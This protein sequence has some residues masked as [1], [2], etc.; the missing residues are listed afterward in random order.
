[1][2]R[3]FVLL[4]MAP[5][6]A[7]AQVP[8]VGDINVYGLRHQTA[9]KLL[10]AASIESGAPLPPS[11]GDVEDKLETVPGVVAARLEAVCCDGDRAILFVGI[12][13]RGGAHFETRP[14]PTG[15]AVLPDDVLKDYRE[16]L[17]VVQRAAQRG[18]AED[19]SMGEPRMS[20]AAARTFEERF[21]T[22]VAENLDQVREVLRNSSDAEQRAVAAGTIGFAAKKDQVINDLQYALQDPDE[23]VRGNAVRSLK[24][25]AVLAQKRPELGLRVSPTW[26]VAMLNSLVLSDRQQAAEALVILTD[27]SNPGALDLMRERALPALIEMARWKTLRYALPSFLLV[28]RIAGIS[29][30]EL[31]AQWQK[32]DRETAIR[33]ASAPAPKTRK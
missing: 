6:I 30:T 23:S 16:Y 21:A 3:P 31:H 27:K 28:G 10:K 4:A 11:K 9:D 1:V 26:F 8:K 2:V 18:A 33:L 12:E 15:I 5:V 19:Y 25:I 29:D 17:S 32:G 22:F 20:D 7:A 14:A 24:A 13:E